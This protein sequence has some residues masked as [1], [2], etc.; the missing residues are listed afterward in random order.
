MNG[1]LQKNGETN[2]KIS[3]VADV[4]EG[5][6]CTGQKWHN[7]GYTSQQRWLWITLTCCQKTVNI[8]LQLTA[9][10]LKEQTFLG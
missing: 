5:T 4:S 8:N 10:Q 7:E 2:R 3:H 6:G 9:K 1:D